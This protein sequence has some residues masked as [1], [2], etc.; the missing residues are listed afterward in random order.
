M[1]TI[2]LIEAI[3]MS[4]IALLLSS[5]ING[6]PS[7]VGNSSVSSNTSSTASEGTTDVNDIKTDISHL[8]SSH[9]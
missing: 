1:K 4:A 5:C 7:H 2:R 3:V 6:N 9:C 8:S